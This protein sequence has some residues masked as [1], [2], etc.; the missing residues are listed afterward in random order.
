[1]HGGCTC[2]NHFRHSGE[3]RF[4]KFIR[5]SKWKPIHH[6]DRT[7]YYIL[8]SLLASVFQPRD[9]ILCIPGVDLF[10][11]LIFHCHA[12]GSERIYFQILFD[13]MHGG[14]TCNNHF[15]HSGEYRFSKFIH[16]G[17]KYSD[18]PTHLYLGPR[19]LIIGEIST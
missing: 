2:N 13:F 9:Y 10:Q 14:C 7:Y 4:S 12:T 15:R 19:F 18:F 6:Y 8:D 5:H 11:I 17:S 16:G 1:M 3:Y